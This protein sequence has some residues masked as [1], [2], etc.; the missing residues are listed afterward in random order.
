MAAKT[1]NESGVGTSV[2]HMPTIKP[3]DESALSNFVSEHDTIVTVEEHQVTGG[4]GGAVAEWLTSNQP[5]R[6]MRIGVQ[7]VFG[8]SGAP[9]EL[10]AHYGMDSDSIVKSITAAL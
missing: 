4:L 7:D 8:Q 3:L 2:L 1:L 10:V 6:L 5:K 9:E